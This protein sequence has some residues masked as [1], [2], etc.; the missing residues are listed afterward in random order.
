[1]NN[2]LLI[3]A[4]AAIGLSACAGVDTTNP[5]SN[6]KMPRNTPYTVLGAASQAMGASPMFETLA[7]GT[8]RE[9]VNN[10]GVA[11]SWRIEGIENNVIHAKSNSGCNDLV[12][13]EFFTVGGPSKKWWNCKGEDS[14]N[15]EIEVEEGQIWPLQVGNTWKVKW[16]GNSTAGRYW[17][18]SKSC[19]V[20]AEERIQ[21][22]AGEYDTYK[23]VCHS[24]STNRKNRFEKVRYV[25]PAAKAIVAGSNAKNGKVTRTYALEAIIQD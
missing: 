12:N 10:E 17:R 6:A 15:T 5:N 13:I 4:L 9:F 22:P 8:T 1:M 14:E 24:R 25:A 3:T 18:N 20:T 11:Y 23:V 2:K 7:V 21:T 16:K 19:E